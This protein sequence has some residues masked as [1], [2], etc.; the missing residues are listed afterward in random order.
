MR[1]KFHEPVLVNET[2]DRLLV[3]GLG[4]LVVDCTL[5]GGGHAE[6][7]LRWAGPG[8]EKVERL[9]GIDRDA[10]AI[11]EAAVRLAEFKERLVIKKGTYD[12]LPEILEEEGVDKASGVLFDLGASFH[13]L[14]S[15]GRGMSF[16]DDESL[17]M[18]MDRESGP[19]AAELL[20]ELDE[21]SLAGLI[22][23]YGEERRSRRIAGAIVR[24]REKSG[25]IRTA[26]ELRDLVY[27][28]TPA[29]R[30]RGTGLHPATRTFMALRIA[31][32]RELEILEKAMADLPGLLGPGGRA[33]VISYHSLEDRIVKRAF[34]AE[35]RGCSC[36]P[37][38]PVC[39]CGGKPRMR[40]LTRKPV[41]PSPEEI[42]ANPAARSAKLR[43]AER[44]G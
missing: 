39:V 26:A 13:Q 22:W 1:I 7:V 30:K 19:T 9:I 17:D 27:S 15:R 41:T 2:L 34:A 24:R 21:A 12:E 11:K 44:I 6:K 38:L 25:P 32:N 5:G 36:P 29:D 31:V 37:D 40:T 23:K 28:A 16:N 4:M 8:G 20:A 18:R 10:E 42:K 33:V 43:A 14:T 3:P 35:S